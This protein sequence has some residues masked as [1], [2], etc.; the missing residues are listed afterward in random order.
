VPARA[1][2]TSRRNKTRLLFIVAQ[3]AVREIGLLEAQVG[4]PVEHLGYVSRMAGERRGQRDLAPRP[5]KR[6]PSAVLR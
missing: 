3:E 6:S 2:W 1:S 5:G 4:V